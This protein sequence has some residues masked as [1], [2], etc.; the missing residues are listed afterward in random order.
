MTPTVDVAASVSPST[1]R[2]YQLFYLNSFAAIP[3]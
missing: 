3:T 1:G 2:H